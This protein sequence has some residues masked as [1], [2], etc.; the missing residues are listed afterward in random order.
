[1]SWWAAASLI[2]RFWITS[3]DTVWK[4][5]NFSATSYF[6]WNQYLAT[7]LNPSKLKC[8]TYYFLDWWK[9]EKFTFFHTV[10]CSLTSQLLPK[11]YFGLNHPWE[12]GVLMVLAQKSV[13]LHACYVFV[14]TQFCIYV[15]LSFSEKYQKSNWLL[16]CPLL[17]VDDVMEAK[18]KKA[19]NKVAY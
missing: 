15:I 6:T 16:Y 8:N 1:M 9:V 10:N 19:E 3:N 2:P 13:S 14:C 4:F 18:A 7:F 17:K 12:D 5:N 11:H